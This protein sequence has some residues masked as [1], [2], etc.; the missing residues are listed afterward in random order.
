MKTT[1]E[2]KPTYINRDDRHWTKNR[3]I[4]QFG[5][6]GQTSLM[7]WADNLQEALDES[8]DWIAEN[9]PGLLCNEQVEEAFKEALAEGKSEEEAWEISEQ[10]TICGGNCGNR[11]LS[12]EWGI[13][14]ENPS[15]AQIKEIAK[16]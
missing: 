16:H 13:L 15:K 8:I 4:L 7:V 14:A 9:E 2:M 11:I 1:N 5:A 6:Y 12:W 10:D 3:F